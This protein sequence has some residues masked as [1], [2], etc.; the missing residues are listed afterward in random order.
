MGCFIILLLLILATVLAGP[1][2]F[3]LVAAAIVVWALVTGS[4]RL[5]WNVL[6]LPFRLVDRMLRDG[7]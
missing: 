3:L 4:L 7:R 6:L 1:F 5:L 2:G